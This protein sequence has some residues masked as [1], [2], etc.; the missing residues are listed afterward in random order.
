MKALKNLSLTPLL[1]T[2]PAILLVAG[3][4]GSGPT[5]T[6]TRTPV[7]GV[8]VTATHTDSY[9]VELWTG[10]ALTGMMTAFP[11]MSA[12]DQGQPVNRHM[13]IH[14]FDKNTGA[15]LIDITPR[16]KLTDVETGVSR[17]WAATQES[18]GSLGVAFVTACLISKHREVEP[19]FGDNIYLRDGAYA[20]TIGI[21]DETA[22][23]ELSF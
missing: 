11:I 10:P 14:L 19:H 15:K 1:F 9:T 23:A 6:P 8:A 13:E 7:P 18:G 22:E 5:A 21:E 3:C 2:L 12:M 16:V 20:V 17:E 4:G